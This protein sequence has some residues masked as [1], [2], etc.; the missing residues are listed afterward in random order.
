MSACFVLGNGPSL[1]SHR[2]EDIRRLPVIGTNRSHEYVE[3]DQHVVIDQQCFD[4]YGESLKAMC[5]RGV[6]LWC[7]PGSPFG[8][9]VPHKGRR[10][11][12]PEFSW[13]ARREIHWR[14]APYAAIQVAVTHGYSRI[15]L[16]GVDLCEHEGRGHFYDRPMGLSLEGFQREGFGFIA[17]LVSVTHEFH[18]YTVSEITM[19][20]AFPRVTMEAVLREE[21]VR[22]EVESA[23]RRGEE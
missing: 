12:C 11:G 6:P 16:L 18:V 20:R 17:G 2:P 5:D 1:S 8:R 19:L 14:F 7:P 21:D 3:S 23:I 13:D 22:A 4:S 15:Y 10:R 9:V